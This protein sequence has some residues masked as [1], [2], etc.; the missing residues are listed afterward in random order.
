MAGC[1]EH[2]N[3]IFGLCKMLHISGP[4]E[5]LLARQALLHGLQASA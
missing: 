4:A 3:E 5:E 2:G 1:C